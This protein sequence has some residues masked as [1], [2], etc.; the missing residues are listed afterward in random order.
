MLDAAPPLSEP[1]TPLDLDTTRE[2]FRHVVESRR[3]VRRFDGAGVPEEVVRECLRLA[4]LAPNSSNLQPWEFYWARTPELREQIATACMGQS[5]ART[6]GELIAIVARTRTWRGHARQVLK[7]WPAE[8]VPRV[9]RLYYERLAPIMYTQGLFGEVGLLK[10]LVFGVLGLTRPVPR[11]PNSPADMRVWAVKSTALAAE[12]LMLAFRA[13]GY[14][15]C[16]MEGM[17]SRRVRRILQIPRDGIITMV[18][19]VGTAAPGG[20]YHDQLRFSPEQFI[21]ER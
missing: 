6:A 11:E 13:H 2:A 19:G 14:D 20:I 16:P 12:N 18:L 3:S 9:V 8:H 5:A 17:D 1:E 10:R 15:T 7:Q 4:M 21:I